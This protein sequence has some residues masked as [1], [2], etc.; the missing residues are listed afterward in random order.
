MPNDLRKT[1]ADFACLLYHLWRWNNRGFPELLRVFDSA[2]AKDQPW[3][4][5]ETPRTPN[6]G[7]LESWRETV[8]RYYLEM[9]DVDGLKSLFNH[10]VSV[11]TEIA[12]QA[13]LAW[14]IEKSDARLALFLLANGAD[15]DS[16]DR[17]AE[18]LLFAAIRKA[19]A[20]PAEGSADLPDF[21]VVV[22]ALLE[23]GADIHQVNSS[24]RSPL[25]AACR[26]NH[27][28]LVKLLI[29]RGADV[30]RGG[31]EESPLS[32]AVM[33]NHLEIARHLLAHGAALT[34]CPDGDLLLSMAVELENLQ[35]V[36]LLLEHGADPQEPG[37][38]GGNPFFHSVIYTHHEGI[39]DAL[40]QAG[41]DI[42]ARDSDGEGVLHI[43]IRRFNTEDD[44]RWFDFLLKRGADI[45]M[46]NDF[47]ETPLEHARS[48]GNKAAI[49]Y[50][51]TRGADTKRSRRKSPSP[52]EYSIPREAPAG[53][54]TPVI[55]RTF[56]D[57]FHQKHIL[58]I[59]ITSILRKFLH[60]RS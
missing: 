18:P 43:G 9:S 46:T 40:L 24:G 20:T 25:Y 58:I 41:A 45:E 50:F 2:P 51:L 17:Y 55:C 5:P 29:E 11:H 32:L 6:K 30:N 57:D 52:S 28:P 26:E 59:R 15:P 27:L 22:E 31:A 1:L 13:L 37:P 7:M 8:L 56:I 19:G 38:Y 3:K 39:A 35:M 33:E 48:L 44:A 12:G 60:I 42:N 21:L 54:D 14:A 47:A 36:E 34:K 10:G 16:R 23:K 53:V 49:E 4:I